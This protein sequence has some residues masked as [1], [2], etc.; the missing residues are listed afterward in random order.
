MREIVCF[1]SGWLHTRLHWIP[2][3][4]P[5]TKIGQASS[6]PLSTGQFSTETKLAAIQGLCLLLSIPFPMARILKV[7]GPLFFLAVI[8][9]RVGGR[10]R[11][12]KLESP[13]VR[14]LF[15]A[16]CAQ[17]LAGLGCTV[18]CKS[19]LGLFVWWPTSHLESQNVQVDWLCAES[20]VLS[21]LIHMVG[22]PHSTIDTVSPLVAAGQ[23]LKWRRRTATCRR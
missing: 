7:A 2:R 8:L 15:L 13:S 4:L 14:S 18:R 21:P 9:P 10:G 11:C 5:A 19:Q 22:L 20:C 12:S 16:L 1:N 23:R 6:A 17:V 3:Y